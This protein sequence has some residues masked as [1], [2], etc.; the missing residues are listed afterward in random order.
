MV[1][2][3]SRSTEATS[4]DWYEPSKEDAMMA[5]DELFY[6][7]GRKPA[8]RLLLN[9]GS[10]RPSRILRPEPLNRWFVTAQPDN[11]QPILQFREF[12]Q[13]ARGGA[14]PPPSARFASGWC[15]ER[16]SS[17]LTF[18][19]QPY[20][21]LRVTPW[22]ELPS[23]FKDLCTSRGERAWPDTGLT[24]PSSTWRRARAAEPA[25]ALGRIGDTHFAKRPHEPA[26]RGAPDDATGYTP[27]PSVISFCT[28]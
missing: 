13:A 20:S 10:T 19:V 12:V 18:R 24:G 26:D 17:H 1:S 9:G 22:D 16:T 3:A 5:D 7:P 11:S 2:G 23:R 4:D 6:T 28:R 15:I 25:E 21:V 14:R 27:T 8:L